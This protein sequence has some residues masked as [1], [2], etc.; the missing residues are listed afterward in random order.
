V[1]SGVALLH[2]RAAVEGCGKGPRRRRRPRRVGGRR[3]SSSSSQSGRAEGLVIVLAERAGGGPHRRPRRAGG[4]RGREAGPAEEG[5]AADL[6]ERARAAMV[7]EREGGEE[8]SV[9]GFPS[10]ASLN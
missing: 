9:G 6:R 2:V 7:G 10:R 1:G 5:G 4:R 8:V 3:A